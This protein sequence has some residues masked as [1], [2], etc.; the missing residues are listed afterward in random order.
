MSRKVSFQCGSSDPT[1]TLDLTAARGEPATRVVTNGSDLPN[2]RA[3]FSPFPRTRVTSSTAPASLRETPGFSSLFAMGTLTNLGHTMAFDRPLPMT[4]VTVSFT[5]GIIS[6]SPPTSDSAKSTRG[7]STNANFMRWKQGSLSSNDDKTTRRGPSNCSSCSLTCNVRPMTTT[8]STTVGSPHHRTSKSRVTSSAPAPRTPPFVPNEFACALRTDSRLSDSFP[9]LNSRNDIEMPSGVILARIFP[10]A[11]P[12][13]SE[14]AVDR[15]GHSCASAAFSQTFVSWPGRLHHSGKSATMP[16]KP[17]AETM[18]SASAW[19]RRY[20]VRSRRSF[21]C[22]R[23]K[24]PR[25]VPRPCGGEYAESQYRVCGSRGRGPSTSAPG[26]V[27][28][29]S[30]RFGHRTWRPSRGDAGP[31]GGEEASGCAPA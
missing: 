2:V 20:G 26:R 27:A 11:P 28:V 24:R 19:L 5:P 16:R 21:N 31:R 23:F 17:P 6:M 25:S 15:C 13:L 1:T 10:T 9:R 7:W 4:S 30:G 8:S 29:G 12:I 18:A 3:F 22:R 14:S